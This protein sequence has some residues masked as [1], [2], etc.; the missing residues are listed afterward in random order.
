MLDACVSVSDRLAFLHSCREKAQQTK[1]DDATAVPKPTAYIA[2][3][4]G[5]DV[6]PRKVMLECDYV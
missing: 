4:R 2:G 6:P 1:T 5:R 3:L